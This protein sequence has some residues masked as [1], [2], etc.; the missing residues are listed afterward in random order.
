MQ[1]HVA[2]TLLALASPVFLSPT[3]A[4]G[5]VCQAL[6]SEKSLWQSGPEGDSFV[7]SGRENIRQFVETVFN[8]AHPGVRGMN[9]LRRVLLVGSVVLSGVF[10]WGG[11]FYDSSLLWLTPASISSTVL[12]DLAF[13]AWD[14]GPRLFFE[15]LGNWASQSHQPVPPLWVRG[16]VVGK[17]GEQMQI[18][19]FTA[20][21]SDSGSS[22]HGLRVKVQG[23]GPAPGSAS[24]STP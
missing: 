9:H 20:V 19:L 11:V 22:L 6:Q 5:R 3:V 13:E 4:Q 2:F 17:D 21:T 23:S 7:I 10:F 15:S 8:H 16:R 1:K 14:Q 18:V 24:R 12:V